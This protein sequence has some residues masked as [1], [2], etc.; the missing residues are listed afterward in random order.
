MIVLLYCIIITSKRKVNILYIVEFFKHFV[1]GLILIMYKKK[2]LKETKLISGNL[3]NNS[4]IISVEGYSWY[5]SKHNCM[6]IIY[7][8]LFTPD[9][10]KKR[11]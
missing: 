3:K 9:P 1:S 6:I 4:L 5:K 7:W 2:L 8:M 10:I 11:G